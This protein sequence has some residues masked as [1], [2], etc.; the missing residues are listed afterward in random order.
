MRVNRYLAALFFVLVVCWP[1]SAQDNWIS[2][3]SKNFLL[4]GNA[5]EKQIRQVGTRLEQFRE[6]FA[7]LFGRNELESHVPTTVVIFK[8]HYSFQPFKPK[9]NTAGFF[10]TNSYVNYITLTTE[11]QGEQDP[12]S[13][14]FHQYTHLLVSEINANMPV[15]FD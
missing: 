2:V 9:P 10:Q 13:V 11:L 15:W 7:R 14:T 8:S 12:L 6:A 5:N 3:R 1:I 4:V